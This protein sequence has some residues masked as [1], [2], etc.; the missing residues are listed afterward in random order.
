VKVFES[1][2]V[3]EVH[4]GEFPVLLVYVVLIQFVVE[5]YVRLEVFREELKM[6][7]KVVDDLGNGREVD[8][9]GF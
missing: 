9:L 7:L 3:F 5:K 8:V 2:E 4:F 6:G 1:E